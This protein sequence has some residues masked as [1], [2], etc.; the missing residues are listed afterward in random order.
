MNYQDFDAVIL[1]DGDFPRHDIPLAVLNGC[2]YLC[3]CDHAAEEAARHGCHIDAIVGDSDSLSDAFKTERR[4]ILH[5]VSEQEDNDQ[6]KATRFCA[7]KGFRRIA[8]LGATGKR[9][10]HTLGNI[11]LLTDYIRDFGIQPMMITDHGVFIPAQGKNIFDVARG[12]QVSVFNKSC[13]RLT[14][15]GLRWQLRPFDSLWQGT[16]NEALG[17]TITIDGDGDYLVYMAFQ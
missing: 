11:S 15:E 9:E 4:D 1:G 16:L 7:A 13:T 10:D 8:Y 5:L 6:T 2:H 14:G 17:E 3:C 12:Q